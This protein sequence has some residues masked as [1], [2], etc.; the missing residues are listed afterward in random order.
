MI[1][2]YN[3]DVDD[4]KGDNDSD[5]KL[6][7]VITM[8]LW[9]YPDSPKFVNITHDI[10]ESNANQNVQRWMCPVRE[11]QFSWWTGGKVPKENVRRLPWAVELHRK[12]A[13]KLHKCTGSDSH[14]QRVLYTAP[15]YDLLVAC[16]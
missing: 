15:L 13:V 10:N 5:D 4:Y 12:G 7:K 16:F 9:Q 3:E 14:G 6:D 1:S 11:L 8:M 2:C